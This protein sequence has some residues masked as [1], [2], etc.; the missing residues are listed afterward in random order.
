MADTS[1]DFWPEG[2]GPI[3]QETPATLLREQ[4]AK[5]GPK[6]KNHVTAIVRRDAEQ[7]TI[8]HSLYLNAPAL[9]NY[10]YKVLNIAHLATNYPVTL[11]DE[12]RGYPVT[13]NYRKLLSSQEVNR[14]HQH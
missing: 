14:T 3:P 1:E 5:L 2:F 10:R 8:Y 6:T 9:G 4:A 7:G 13:L 11:K 12:L